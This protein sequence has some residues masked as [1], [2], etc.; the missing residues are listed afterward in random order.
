[1]FLVCIPCT[2]T[3]ASFHGQ[4]F[5]SRRQTDPAQ[6]APFLLIDAIGF[7][8]GEIFASLLNLACCPSVRPRGLFT[9]PNKVIS[10]VASAA[11][12]AQQNQGGRTK[13]KCRRT[14]LDPADLPTPEGRRRRQG[15][16]QFIHRQ[17]G[18]SMAT[19]R[20]SFAVITLVK[21]SNRESQLNNTN[22]NSSVAL[23]P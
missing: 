7:R 22:P 6:L 18:F 3:N 12:R 1:M 16:F 15:R 5:A 21:S 8:R 2:P 13:C 23:S 17:P 4:F 20:K 14:R 11:A 10:G 9:V 19:R